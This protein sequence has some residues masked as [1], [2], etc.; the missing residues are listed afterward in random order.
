[1]M[2]MR[3]RLNVFQINLE[4]VDRLGPQTLSRQFYEEPYTAE[5]HT[6]GTSFELNLSEH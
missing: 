1:M 5:R 4:Y 6:T 3:N 2:D